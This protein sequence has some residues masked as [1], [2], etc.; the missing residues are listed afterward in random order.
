MHDTYAGMGVQKEYL[1]TNAIKNIDYF[2]TRGQEIKILSDDNNA[3]IKVIDNNVPNLKFKISKLK[4]NQDVELEL[5]RLYYLGYDIQQQNGKETQKINYKNSKNGFVKIK[6]DDNG[7]VTVN[8][9]GTIFYRV[10]KLIRLIFILIFILVFLIKIIKN[11]TT[12]LQICRN[13]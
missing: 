8:Y 12:K 10:S 11:N 6:L 9:T 5:P 3:K 1:T 7:I 2:E 4:E 13:K